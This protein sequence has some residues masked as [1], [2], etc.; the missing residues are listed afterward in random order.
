MNRIGASNWKFVTLQGEGLR[1]LQG[2]PVT[3]HRQDLS[4]WSATMTVIDRSGARDKI[5]ELSY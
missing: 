4:P 3:P 1:L 5:T 2:F